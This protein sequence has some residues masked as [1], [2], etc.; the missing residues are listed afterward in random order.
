MLGSGN[1][2]RTSDTEFIV[3]A[4]QT[5]RHRRLLEL[6]NSGLLPRF[7]KGGLTDAEKSARADLRSQFGMNRFAGAAGWSTTSFQK[8]LGAPSD[9]AGLVA[10]LSQARTNIKAATSGGTESRLLRTLDAVG[11]KLI[12]QE[13]ALGRV[14]ASLEK[15]RDK[16]DSLKSAAAS[17]SSSVKSGIMTSAN[18]TSGANSGAPVTV[19]SIMG[20][21]KESR[22][23][24]DAFAQALKDLKEK[25]LDKGL[26][27][28][29]AQAGTE[30]G[31]LETAS[32]LL[33]A[34]ESEIKSLNKLRV[35]I[36]KSASSAGATAADAMYGA[37]IKAQTAS[38]NRLQQ[39]QDKLEKS[40]ATLAK[41]MEKAISKAIGKK[42]GGGIVGGSGLTMVGEQGPELLDLAVGS[43]V[44]SNPD[45]RR[46]MGE[47]APWASML[48]APRGGAAAGKR[49]AVGGAG[50]G[51]PIVVNQ[52]ITL[53]GKVLARQI[54]DPLRMETRVRGVALDGR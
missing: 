25:G 46:L 42:A 9:L 27:A 47:A 1:M 24:G 12:G 26:I 41:V 5:K 19:A 29:I 33:G 34:S 16:L 45:S 53:D 23:K 7:A 40:M 38:V 36:I 52:T 13:K 20:G 22:D 37:A 28:E 54:F 17:L 39:S 48:N 50:G 3:N 4:Q 15:A 31:G 30:G 10:A 18:I 14:N 21:L 32:A 51:R 49:G 11:K 6:I 35:D 44:W 8:G 43:R 2:V